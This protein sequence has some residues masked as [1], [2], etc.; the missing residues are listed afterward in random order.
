MKKLI[1]TKEFSYNTRMLRAGDTFEASGRDAMLLVG[2]GKARQPRAAVELKGPPANVIAKV[3]VS[4]TD[5]LPA[6]RA[7]Y[8]AKFGKRP[9]MGWD[10][11]TVRAKLAESVVPA[12]EPVAA[13][14]A[15]PAPTANPAP[16]EPATAP[17]A[18]S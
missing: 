2:I 15:E 14:P 1:A 9:H 12:V 13:E 11:E 3:A 10:L 7:E 18:L 17:N 5:E 8:Q 16:V 4:A 6:A